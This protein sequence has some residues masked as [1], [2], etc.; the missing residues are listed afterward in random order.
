MGGVVPNTPSGGRELE[1]FTT[2]EADRPIITV[3]MCK[4]EHFHLKIQLQK[5]RKFQFDFQENLEISIM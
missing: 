5:L 3:P 1:H 4:S 2:V